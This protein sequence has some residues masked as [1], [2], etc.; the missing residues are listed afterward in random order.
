MTEASENPSC[1]AHQQPTE[2]PAPAAP[3]THQDD[4]PEEQSIN[5]PA[6]AR[7]Q[8]PQHQEAGGSE[9]DSKTKASTPGN[10]AAET[11]S[12]PPPRQ[13]DNH[14]K[15][16]NNKAAVEDTDGNP[17]RKR[18][19]ALYMAY[20]GHGYSGMQAQRVA[21]HVKTIEEDLF[22]AIHAA[23]GIS[24]ANADE[25]G[26]QKIHWARAARTDKGVSAV[27]QVVSLKMVMHPPGVIER[28]NDS[29]PSQIRVFGARRVTKGFDAR[30]SC[31]KR[32]YEY[33]LPAW[34]F[35]PREALVE[36]VG[37]AADATAVETEAA[38]AAAAPPLESQ[39]RQTGPSPPSVFTFDEACSERLTSILRQFEGTH[40][41]HNYTLR[42]PHNSRCAKRY[43]VSF[44]CQGVF[45][46]QGQ[47][48]VRMVVIG[49]SFMLHQ[50]RKMVAMAVATYLD[51][52]P[53]HCL[54]HA[55]TTSASLSVPM[56]PEL[57]LFLDE[58]YYDYYNSK[59]SIQH[60]RLSLEDFSKDVNA[61]KRE[62]VY[63]HIAER[64]AAEGVNAGWL[65]FMRKAAR[66]F[67]TWDTERERRRAAP[68][69]NAGKRRAA[70][71]AVL[72]RKLEQEGSMEYEDGYG[73][74]EERNAEEEEDQE[75]EE[76]EQKRARGSASDV[77]QGQQVVQVEEK[78]LI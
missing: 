5:P 41:F 25:R 6:D 24:D 42:T 18:K 30:K 35:A 60:E 77:Q 20:V 28:I 27:G 37:A 13:D 46:I 33:V 73:E 9:E 12:A 4:R 70:A 34:L 71:A 76:R 19:V 22:K 55:L 16:S 31:D 66:D 45:E 74:E 52:A 48:W 67:S 54:R 7:A 68:Q 11:K 72:N 23:G 1:I 47:P 65:E 26:F 69:S 17:A 8:P 36:D 40:N 3:P 49:Q 51:I 58:C 2:P 59:W 50:I 53:P 64:D 29:L 21:E 38:D 78:N 63:P 56:A 39:Q 61:F 75:R 32:R 57:G 10:P 14:N 43:I 15:N 62:L 44:R